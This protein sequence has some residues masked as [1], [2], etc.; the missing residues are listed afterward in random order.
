VKTPLLTVLT[1]PV[2]GDL[3]RAYGSLRRAVRPLV[4]PGAPLP[5]VSPYPGHYAVVRSVV[6]G[7]RAIGAD[8]N[9]NPRSLRAVGRAVY[10]PANEA[11]RQ[12][13]GLKRRGR[14]DY[15]AAGPVNA[16]WPDEADGVLRQP[17]I[18][19]LIVASEWVRELYRAE[20]PDLCDKVGVCQAGVDPGYW[21]PSPG[22][23]RSGRA[24]VYW[25]SGPEAFC[26]A[27][28]A[29]VAGFGLAP[30][31]VRYGAY[32]RDGYRRLLDHAEAAVFLSHFE[33]QGLALAEAWAMDVP[34]AVWDP[35]GPAELSGRRFTA[36]SSCPFLTPETGRA[37]RTL[38][39]LPAALAALSAGRAGLAPRRWVL[40]HMTDAVC[41]DALYRM[42][43]ADV[44]RR[45]AAAG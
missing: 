35:R 2:P 42:I 19:R 11:L 5:E 17:E 23:S 25:K 15:L 4:K 44:G 22:R 12:A 18:D 28:E 26:A 6:E 32:G 8:F 40:R 21:Q 24:V 27:V 3:R 20:A 38:D 29:A 37:W 45:P 16:F 31:R 13:A 36:G 9:F 43:R 30:V 1:A 33:T 34:T 10:A 39:E 41:A 14:I 7:L